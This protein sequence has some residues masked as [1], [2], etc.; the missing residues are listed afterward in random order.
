[1]SCELTQ[2][3]ERYP[4]SVHIAFETPKD[5]QDQVYELVKAIG[6]DGKIRKEPMR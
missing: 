5:I 3:E 4:M 1:M 6:K 2:H